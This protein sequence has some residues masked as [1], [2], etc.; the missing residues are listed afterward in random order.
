MAIPLYLAK[1]PWEFAQK[2]SCNE[3]S[4]WMACR[5]SPSGAGLNHVPE[6]LPKNT[7]LI[8]DDMIPP[9]GHSINQV[10]TTLS[11]I[12]E[13]FSCPGILLDFQRPNN[14][15][16]CEMIRSILTLSCPVIVSHIYAA[17]LNCPIFL[18]PIPPWMIPEEYIKPWQNRNIWL[19]V[20][21]QTQTLTITDNGCRISE[22]IYGESRDLPFH[23]ENLCCHYGID[24]SEKQALFTLN[25]NKSHI[26]ALLNRLEQFGVKGCVGLYEDFK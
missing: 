10:K 14:P 3:N 25:R 9:Q 18:P 26:S 7:L 23:S 22:C 5:F 12:A 8:L 20:A 19:E 21:I 24:L 13:K 1:N 11:H 6:Q 17:D 2:N 15:E 16:S 4:A